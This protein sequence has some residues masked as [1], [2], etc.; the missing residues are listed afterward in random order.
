MTRFDRARADYLALR[1]CCAQWQN[2]GR[3]I[4]LHKEYLDARRWYES[5]LR[6]KRQRELRRQKREGERQAIAV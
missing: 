2:C 5:Q 6:E 4:S 3:E 1:R